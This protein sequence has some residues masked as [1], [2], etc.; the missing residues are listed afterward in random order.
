VNLFRLFGIRWCLAW[1]EL[2]FT[3]SA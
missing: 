3:V 1:S 2:D